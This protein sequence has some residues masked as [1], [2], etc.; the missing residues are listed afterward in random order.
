MPFFA[1]MPITMIT[2][3]KDEMLKVVPVTNSARRTADVDNNA[4]VRIA[5]GAANVRNS[6]RGK[7]NTSTTARA[8][9]NRRS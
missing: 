9:T 6:N 8:R 7:T 5:R 2:P 4:E 3:M 1:T